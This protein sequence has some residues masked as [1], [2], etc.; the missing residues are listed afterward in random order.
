MKFYSNDNSDRQSLVH[1]V[2]GHCNLPTVSASFVPYSLHDI[3]RNVN[4][5]YQQV[6]T[7]IWRSSGAWQYDDSNNTDTPKASITL[8][9]ASASYIIPTTALRIEGIEILNSAGIWNKIRQIDYNDITE[10][11]EEYLGSGGET[12]EYDLI[13]NEIRLF[14]PPISSCVTLASG[15]CIR[16][17]RDVT[18]F[19]TN[20]T[21]ASTTS[22][23]FAAP[24]HEIL[25]LGAA[26]DFVEDKGAQDR[27]VTMKDRLEKGLISFYGHRN[28]VR[29]ARI[30][31]S[32]K[33][34]W[35]NY[36]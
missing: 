11:P 9:E 5:H 34:R 27:L 17:S 4:K 3:T 8:G 6:A 36:I 35:R 32:G 26:I 30:R 33:R 24:F 23:G 31:P 13:G 14:P 20:G 15:M 12:T 16:L 25:S 21:T 7:L 28:V 18:I 29:Q 10:S 22:P 2:L 19:T 1:D